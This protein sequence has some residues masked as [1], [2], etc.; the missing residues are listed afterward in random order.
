MEYK[1]NVPDPMKPLEKE[2]LF[3]LNRALQSKVKELE[4]ANELLTEALDESSR[5]FNPWVNDNEE[6]RR[7]RLQCLDLAIIDDS[8]LRPTEKV[9]E[10]AQAYY[11]WITQSQT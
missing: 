7:L 8:A 1:L 2:D 11:E 4:K 9:L 6:E 3:L 10:I 5:D